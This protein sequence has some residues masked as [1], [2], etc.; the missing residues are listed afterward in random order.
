[1]AGGNAGHFL[2]CW[3]A[4]AAL[5]IIR[6]PPVCPGGRTWEGRS[7]FHHSVRLAVLVT[8]VTAM[9]L[10]AACN[11]VKTAGATITPTPT[12]TAT[13][14][15]S[16][17][18]TPNPTNTA[19]PSPTATATPAPASGT[20][21]FVWATSYVDIDG[22]YDYYEVDVAAAA[23]ANTTVAFDGTNAI[24]YFL[25][26]YNPIDASI[27]AAGIAQTG[28]IT[29]AVNGTAI[30]AAASFG[31]SDSKSFL[32]ATD[33]Y[34]GVSTSYGAEIATGGTGAFTGMLSDPAPNA[35]I[36]AGA[37][38]IDAMDTLGNAETFGGASNVAFD[39]ALCTP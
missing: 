22:T 20:C 6:G 4:R 33:Y 19:T 18:P 25:V 3:R 24:G 11:D 17:T 26:G 32:D 30:G 21:S 5:G 16:G 29:L 13:T 1:M 34:N 23:W 36:S 37:G 38:S 28:A 10:L 14:P 31:D 15:P 8:T 12:S 2:F 7:M 9:S 39:Y 27:Y 35:A